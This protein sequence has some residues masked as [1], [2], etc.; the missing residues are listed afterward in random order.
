MKCHAPLHGWRSKKRSPLGKREVV[1]QFREGFYDVPVTVPCGKCNGCRLARSREWAIRCVHEA[2]L[3]KKNVFVTLTYSEE[4]VPRVASPT[5]LISSLRP[6]DFVNF[7]KRL[8]KLKDGV[9]F[10]QAGEYG[11]LGRPHHHALLFNCDFADRV[12]WRQGP[13]GMLDRSAELE[14]LWPFGYSSVGE[15]TDASAAYVARYTVK[16]AREVAEGAVEDSGRVQEYLTMSRRPGIGAGWFDR[17]EGDVFP[18]DELVT[19]WGV[20]KP[21]R[22]YVERYRSRNPEGFKEV[23]RKRVAASGTEGARSEM[24]ERRLVQKA[25]LARRRLKDYLR[26]NMP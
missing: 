26:R 7:M 2:S 13:T 20:V 18:F 15:V 22:F 19:R 16:K 6:V 14:R 10:L 25:E 1:F 11:S 5:G 3:W 23:Q 21:P 4:F 8:R 12:S 17:F 9:R 24:D